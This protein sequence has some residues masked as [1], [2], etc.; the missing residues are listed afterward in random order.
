LRTLQTWLGTTTCVG[1]VMGARQT[2]KTSLLFKLR[3]LLR[4]KFGFAFVDLQSV[5]GADVRGC[6][7]Y[8]ASEITSQLDTAQ[9]AQSPLPNDG[10]EFLEFLRT[11]AQRGHAIRS[12]L[13][14]DELGALPAETALK[15]AST[16]RAL[17]TNRLIKP[18]YARYMVLL[19]GATDMLQLTTGRN[20]PLRNVTESIYLGDLTRDETDLLLGKLL[21][22]TR[23]S[24]APNLSGHLHGWTDGHPYWTQL[25]A[26][27]LQGSQRALSETA[28]DEVVHEKLH[29]EDKNLPHVFRLLKKERS[30]WNMIDSLL[31]GSALSFTRANPSVARLELIGLVK[32][33]D[34]RCAI[35]NRIYYEAL[36]LQQYRRT[37]FRAN[38][39][40][41]LSQSLSSATQSDSLFRL[42]TT[43]LKT[44]LDSRGVAL[45]RLTSDRLA[46]SLVAS[47]GL[48]DSS[49]AEVKFTATTDLAST[50]GSAFDVAAAN[51]GD[52]DRRQLR[53]LDCVAVVPIREKN[54]TVGFFTLSRTTAARS[55]DRHQLD[56]AAAVAEQV[57]ACQERLQ[58]RE[59]ERDA[60]RAREIQESFL[61]TVIP[62][63]AGVH[64]DARW[65]PAR[66]VS[67][68]YYD[69]LKVA[70]Q[71]LVVCI[72]DVVGKG[73]AAA[74]TMANLQSAVRMRASATALP[75]DVC[76][77]LNRHMAANLAPGRFITFFY[78]LL[79]AAAHRLV[80]TNAGHNAPVLLR[81]DGG[82]QRL[83]IGGAL[84]GPLPD[85]DYQQAQVELRPGDRLLMFTDGACEVW[86]SGGHELGDEGVVD[87]FVKG[88]DLSADKMTAHMLHA[89]SVFAGG[90]FADDVT[91]VVITCHWTEPRE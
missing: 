39:L 18:E 4:R 2:G 65:Q 90:N 89:I 10:R 84:L 83:D 14:L 21:G 66:V 71:K 59:I 8:I 77:E 87:L 7:N 33:K 1:A 32:N 60:E 47:S 38:D 73:M 57:T 30:L 41:R 67:G 44:L 63:A 15:L 49:T 51:L 56:F 46:Y 79:D 5:E 24:A 55:Y 12:I 69:V 23:L 25:L 68:D 6:F 72:G 43:E 82:I 13:I 16:I 37:R 64:V 53:Q 28:I 52:E 36:Q 50:L 42:A 62:Q 20:S 19:A 70:D 85:G 27:A 81:A 78:G 45:F 91:L 54:S 22:R 35:R 31:D 76:R 74:L 11:F 26:G 17:F 3:Y 80:Y 86:N 88:G 58:L 40:R 29:V 48:A 61:P 75:G 34:G 9:T